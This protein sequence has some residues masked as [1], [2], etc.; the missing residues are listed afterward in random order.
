MILHTDKSI[1]DRLLAITSAPSECHSSAQMN[2]LSVQ[3]ILLQAERPAR[4]PVFLILCFLGLANAVYLA[5]AYGSSSH[6]LIC[7]GSGCEIDLT[8]VYS[9]LWG[10]PLPILGVVF[11]AV[12][13][14]LIIG[15][16]LARRQPVT[17]FCGARIGF[18]AAG[19]LV[20][21]YLT[22]IEGFVSHAWCVWCIASDL[23]VT[24]LLV[25]AMWGGWRASPTEA[26]LDSPSTCLY[27][28]YTM[29]VIG[30][31][32][33]A[34]ALQYVFS[35]RMQ[36]VSPESIREVLIRSD[37]HKSGGASA[38]VAVV[39]FGD[40]QCVPCAQAEIPLMRLRE[41]YG[42][43]IGFVFRHLPLTDIHPDAERAAEASECVAQQGKFW[44]AKSMFFAR[45]ADLSD[46]ALKRYA[47]DLGMDPAQFNKCLSSG[48]MAAKVRRDAEDARTLRVPGTP[49]FFVGT[50]M[51]SGRAEFN[52][53][54]QLIDREE[55][56]SI[57]GASLR[58]ASGCSESGAATGN[59][60][61]R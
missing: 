15:N 10:V 12:L 21:L 45:Q 57:P 56:A 54:V 7:L 53:M 46:S 8:S 14:I 43:R 35:R 32:V 48:L 41:K 4:K 38:K 25:L 44:E 16:S 1:S 50:Q 51:I 5:L 3:V 13:V 29:A 39:E 55:S 17:L 23:T 59:C 36:D 42:T 40:F 20:S 28:S 58:N 27:V 52:R 37:S 9:K 26:H 6:A 49:T 30:C 31:L 33:S 2:D 18:W 61:V 60:N 19:L 24:A 34:I 22:F 11:Y 47:V